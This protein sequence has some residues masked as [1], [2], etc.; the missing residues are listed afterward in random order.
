MTTSQQISLSSSLEVSDDVNKKVL[1]SLLQLPGNRICADC[2]VLHPEWASVNLGV[3]ICIHCS[4]AHRNLGTHISKVRSCSL[5]LWEAESVEIMR[6][7]G[8]V[9]ANSLWE[10]N[11]PNTIRKPTEKDSLETRLAFIRAKY[12]RREFM[13]KEEEKKMVFLAWDDEKEGTWLG[14]VLAELAQ[15]VEQLR[16]QVEEDGLLDK[17]TPYQFCFR[18]APVSKAQ[19]SKVSIQT[20]LTMVADNP[21]I[22]LRKQ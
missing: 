22:M 17:D 6:R 9:K 11:L 15:S 12:E 21:T 20:L 2:N 14:F 10:G 5:D 16:V 7:T 8:N 18:K 1:A 13:K 4:G 3:F 19:E